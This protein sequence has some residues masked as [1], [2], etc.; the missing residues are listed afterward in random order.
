[1]YKIDRND[2]H[3]RQTVLPSLSQVSGAEPPQVAA[4]CAIAPRCA[5]GRGCWWLVR[6]PVLSSSME[7]PALLQVRG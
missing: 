2:D 3:S 6:E 7:K 1:M 5:W 4:P